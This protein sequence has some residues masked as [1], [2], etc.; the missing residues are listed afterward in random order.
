VICDPAGVQAV[1]AALSQDTNDVGVGIF[2]EPT[3]EVHL[4]PINNLPNHGGHAELV[5][6]LGL[7]LVECKGFLILRDPSGG[8]QPVNMSH[9]N[10]PQGVP[11][12]LRMPHLT[13]AA[14]VGA[15]QA[16]GL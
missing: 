8:F 14:I 12:A 15:L 7:R 1:K 16:A 5:S 2:H 6:S 10:G 3:G 13:F 4:S 9:L 11:G